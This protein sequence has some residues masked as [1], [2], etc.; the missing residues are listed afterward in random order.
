MLAVSKNVN[1]VVV[2]KNEEACVD[3]VNKMLNMLVVLK[4]ACVGSVKTC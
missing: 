4:R 3:I 1:N 2:L